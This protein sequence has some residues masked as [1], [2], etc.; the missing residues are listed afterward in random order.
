MAWPHWRTAGFAGA[1]SGALVCGE[2][3]CIPL[4]LYM[5]TGYIAALPLRP[6]HGV[7]MEVPVAD[8]HCQCG[9]DGC[10]RGMVSKGV[11]EL[12]VFSS[13]LWW[14][15]SPRWETAEFTED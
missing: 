2:S 8:G 1:A 14:G 5:G 9:G 15:K 3:L 7:R 13:Q 6:T 10:G 4:Y 12:S 11:L